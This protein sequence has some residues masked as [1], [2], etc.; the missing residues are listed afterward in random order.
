M[1]KKLLTLSG[2]ALGLLLILSVPSAFAAAPQVPFNIKT[3]DLQLVLRDLWVGHAFWVRN[4]V[5]Y[6]RFGNAQA[7]K[8]AE[9]QV[10]KNARSIADAVIPY[11]GSEA[12]DKLY[13]L[14]AGHYGAVKEYMNATF[15]RQ[16]GAQKN[17]LAALNS[18][19]VEIADFLSSANPNWPKDT[20]VSLL[21]SHVEDHVNQINDIAK[22]NLTDE[23][24][25]WQ[26]MLQ[27]V[28]TIADA[29]AQGIV[30]QFP[31]KF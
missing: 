31:A 16:A 12:A 29:L 27:N 18:N 11:Y 10:V 2:L 3:V 20:L 7:A 30:K 1:H 22:R 14:L 4:V 13:G 25:V 5:L 8:A 26:S 24:Q 19:A 9:E 17:A 15:K 28:Y 6:T 21:S 23:A